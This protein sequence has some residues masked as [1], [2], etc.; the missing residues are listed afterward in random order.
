MKHLNQ[1][2]LDWIQSEYVK[3]MHTR[4]TCKRLVYVQL[5]KRCPKGQPITQHGHGAQHFSHISGNIHLDNYA[6]KTVYYAPADDDVIIEFPNVKGGLTFF[7]PCTAQ[8][9]RTQR[10]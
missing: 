7:Q 8:C 9:N 1:E 3:F 4:H 5:G 10:R 6:T 2:L